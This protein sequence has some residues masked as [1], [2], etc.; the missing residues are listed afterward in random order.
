MRHRIK[1]DTV[2]TFCMI[3]KH[4]VLLMRVD[5]YNLRQKKKKKKKKGRAE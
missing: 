2:N 4:P 1:L 5:T 3:L